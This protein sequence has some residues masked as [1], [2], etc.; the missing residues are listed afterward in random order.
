VIKIGC[1]GFPVNHQE[2]AARF[3]LVEIQKTF[4][5]PPRLATAQ[6]WRRERSPDF[7][8]TLKA[9]QL[10]THEARGPTYRRLRR[11]LTPEEKT[12]AGAFRP[13]PLVRKAWRTSREMARTLDARIILFQ[14][15]PS[16]TP[17][18]EHLDNLRAFFADAERQ[19]LLFAWEPRGDWPRGLVADLCDDLDLIPAGD[20]LATPPLPGRLAYFRLHGRGGY[21]YTYTTDDFSQ[22]TEILPGYEETYVLFNNSTMWDDAR[23]FAEFVGRKKG[24]V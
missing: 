9:W 5:Q 22:L 11:Q 13:T 16:F 17:T 15:P 19:G 24:N 10:I 18:S 1:C 23:R 2:Y 14:C 3:H 7:E 6:K 20:P 21:R 4:Y 8:F 12:Q